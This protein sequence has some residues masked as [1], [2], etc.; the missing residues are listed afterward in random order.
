[1]VGYVTSTNHTGNRD[2]AEDDLR[3]REWENDDEISYDTHLPS[4]CCL[5]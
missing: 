1:M 5:C 4:G 2:P 3:I